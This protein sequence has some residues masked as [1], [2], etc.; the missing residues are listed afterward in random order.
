MRSKFGLINHAVLALGLLAP[1]LSRA[2]PVE[3]KAVYAFVTDSN[4]RQF[5]TVIG[6]FSESMPG[7]DIRVLNLQGKGDITLLRKFVA[8]NNP[9]LIVALGSISATTVAAL[10]AK[11]PVVFGM[12][13]NHRRYAQLKKNN[14]T[15]VSMEIPARSWLIQFRLLFPELKGI[16]VPYNPD[17]SAEIIRDAEAAAT[18]MQIRILGVSVAD[19]DTIRAKLALEKS[20]DYNGLWMVADFKLYN[21][22]SQAFVSLLEFANENKKP[23]LGASEAFV[24][25]GALF[26][27]SINYQSLGSQLALVARQILEDKTAP[28]A[29]AVSPPIGTY[30]VINKKTGREL[31]GNKFR[32][33][34]LMHAD[35]I[36]P[37]E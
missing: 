2:A 22:D 12:V 29:I 7:A 21:N 5:E 1:A 35:K 14:I 16:A 3:K 18:A 4:I 15:G 23:L 33:E 13:L 37:E 32:E 8:E 10:D 26:S 31:L 19:P 6:G 9:T 27:V 24:K 28:G 20:G 17:A 30:T 34:H 36:Y 25:A 11:T